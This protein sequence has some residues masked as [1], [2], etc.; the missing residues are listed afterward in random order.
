MNRRRGSALL[1]LAFSVLLAPLVIAAEGL[2]PSAIAAR[3]NAFLDQE[4]ANADKYYVDK[5]A[6]SGA[7]LVALGGKIVVSRA[8]GY[9]NREWQVPATTDTKFRIWSITKI[10]TATAIM[11]LHEQ[12]K[13]DI[14]DSI[15]K[16]FD[17]CPQSWQTIKIQYLLSHTSGLPEMAEPLLHGKL[18]SNLTRTKVSAAEVVEQQRNK[19]LYFD[20]G[21]HYGYTNFGFFVAGLIIERVTG[22]SYDEAL[23]ELIF[24]P[25]QMKDTGLDRPEVIL[26]KRASYY[27]NAHAEEWLLNEPPPDAKESLANAE[28]YDM[29][30]WMFAAGALYSTVEDLLKFDRALSSGKLMQQKTLDRMRTPLSGI[31]YYVPGPSEQYASLQGKSPDYA[32]GWETRHVAGRQCFGHFGAGGSTTTRFSHFPDARVTVVV[33][34]NSLAMGAAVDRLPDVVFDWQPGK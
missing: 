21:T 14:E 29:P 11:Q 6:F 3:V 9:A 10:F 19:P 27:A 32:L 23:H 26:L 18:H 1:T 5:D 8:F 34:T 20:P 25:A 28:F 17:R 24:R 15:C 4:R 16:Y 33:L 22:K 31:P 7:V 13:L 30:S 12:G 2:S